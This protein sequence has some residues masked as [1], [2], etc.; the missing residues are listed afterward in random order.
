MWMEGVISQHRS[1]RDGSCRVD[2]TKY[3]RCLKA[4]QKIIRV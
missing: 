3:K 4:K 1:M 2:Q